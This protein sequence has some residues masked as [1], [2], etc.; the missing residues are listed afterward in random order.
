LEGRRNAQPKPGAPQGGLLTPEQEAEIEKFRAE[1]VETRGA[2][3]DVQRRLRTDIDR[4]G[5]WLAAINILLVPLML[6]GTALVLA[7]FRRRK[8]K[9]GGGA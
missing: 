5:N 2:L 4:L 3:R 6:G 8:P 7:L 1:L 9:Q